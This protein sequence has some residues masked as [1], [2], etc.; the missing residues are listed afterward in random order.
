MLAA[1]PPGL[2]TAATGPPE[3]C[4]AAEND[5]STDRTAAIFAC[6]AFTVATKSRTLFDDDEAASPESCS[7]KQS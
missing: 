4:T 1:T 2:N 7:V 5:V 6:W 3:L